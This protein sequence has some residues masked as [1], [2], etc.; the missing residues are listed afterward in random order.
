MSHTLFGPVCA[1]TRAD[2]MMRLL[3]IFA[4]EGIDAWRGQPD[5]ADPIEPTLIRRWRLSV[6]NDV[7]G[8]SVPGEPEVRKLEEALLERARR[9]GHRSDMSELE[10]LAKLRHHGAATRLLDASRNAFISLWFASRQRLDRPGMLV[11]FRLRESSDAMEVTTEMLDW[12][13]ND[14][15]AAGDGRLL[16][17]QPRDLSP[18]IVTQHALLVLGH[19]HQGMRASSLRFG[20]EPIHVPEGGPV[21]DLDGAVCVLITPQL[22][23]SLSGMWHPVFGF[24]DEILFPDFDGFA[25]AHRET[26][27]YPSDFPVERRRVPP[28]RGSDGRLGGVAAQEFS[29]DLPKFNT[30]SEGLHSFDVSALGADL[31]RRRLE[32]EAAVISA[33]GNQPAERVAALA[34]LVE[35]AEL[36]ADFA[37]AAS[38]AEQLRDITTDL[39]DDGTSA[40]AL[41]V[42]SAIHARAG[43]RE[44]ASSLA[45]EAQAL[46]ENAEDQY[47]L[48]IGILQEAILDVGG[49]APDAALPLLDR[50][51]RIA[52]K[53]QFTDAKGVALSAVGCVYLQ[54]G[55]AGQAVPIFNR[56]QLLHERTSDR[57]G[58]GQTHNNVGVLHYG[59]GR[60]VNA[61]PLLERALDL[62]IPGQD[63]I[64]LL[65]VLNNNLRAVESHYLQGEHTIRGVI[66]GVRDLMTDP[67]I[68]RFADLTV[69]RQGPWPDDTASWTYE[70]ENVFSPDSAVLLPQPHRHVLQRLRGPRH[71]RESLA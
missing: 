9:A 33:D 41:I 36:T 51:F 50:A 23:R 38:A 47:L 53:E 25:H 3:T 5:A 45:Q 62:L 13:V 32:A 16:W 27:E 56:A 12:T 4:R 26:A 58:L 55:D 6:G 64:A 66:E 68:R 39:G 24:S 42:R 17:W 2:Q 34:A 60:F 31:G 61:I 40:A 54:Q 69:L 52:R 10:L 8:R 46:A 43:E 35:A 49:E 57:A 7:A 18:R 29:W 67:A 22:K 48:C 63:V 19:T 37:G 15:L 21:G 44:A 28:A 11:G 65:T 14:V 1:P 59:G 30:H 20:S 70:K 71:R